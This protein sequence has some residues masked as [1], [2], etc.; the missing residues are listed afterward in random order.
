MLS[1]ALTSLL[2]GA[3]SSEQNFSLAKARLSWAALASGCDH[4][5]AR[6]SQTEDGGISHAPNASSEKTHKCIHSRAFVV[7][8][9]F[10]VASLPVPETT[11]KRDP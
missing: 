5:S 1:S 7:N 8:F 4:S 6:T 9:L 10:L 2:S 3:G 11:P